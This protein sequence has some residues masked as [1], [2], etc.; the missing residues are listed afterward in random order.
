MY[1]L[2]PNCSHS[3]QISRKQLKIKHG[4]LICSKCK[5]QFNAYLTLSKS[6]PQAL[7]TPVLETPPS[8][9]LAPEILAPEMQIPEILFSES[10]APE[11][12]IPEISALIK[13]QNKTPEETETL[14][15]PFFEKYDWQKIKTTHRP[16]RWLAGIVFG[17]FLLTYQVYYFQGYALSQNPQV[18]PWLNTLSKYVN[19][20]LP[21]Y[22]KPL[23]FTTI[24][25]S[26]E[27]SDKD[28][29]RLQVSF[30]NHAD[31]SQAPPYIQ[32]TLQNLYGGVFAQ[33]IFSPQEY[34]DTENS[35]M[36]IK[37]SGTLDVDFLVAIPDQDIGGYSITLK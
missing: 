34:L 2:C 26:L 14:N 25:S 18:R 32:L 13:P 33:R 15:E 1:T 30:I 16:E 37:S 17:L 31:L 20:K 21:D 7:E 8:G 5:Q 23:E 9:M 27:H 29:Y 11:T 19:I 35:V 28:N 10:P 4:Q 12:K 24:G 22:R 36:P 6:S 3:K